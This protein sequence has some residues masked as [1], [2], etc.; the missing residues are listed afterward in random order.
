MATTR[1]GRHY[2]N[3]SYNYGSTARNI[4][5]RTAIE[6]APTGRP[7]S[8]IR[9]EKL[10]TRKMGMSFIQV[11]FLT[12]AMAVLGMA[13]VSYLRLQSEI[14]S[15]VENVSYQEA[16]LN[17]LTLEN[18]DEYSKMIESINYEEIKR[19]AIEDLGMVYASEDQII[20]YTREN[21]DYVRQVNDLN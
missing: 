17:N 10:R 1:Q 7:L 18:D 9:G 19:S 2:S 21:S 15:L 12:V 13:V 20:T 6:E 8:E 4:D 5:V 11:M 3:N 14:T 16:Y